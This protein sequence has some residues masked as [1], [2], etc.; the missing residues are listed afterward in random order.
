M[1]K[2]SFQLLACALLTALA[3]LL[4]PASA[5]AATNQLS[6]LQDDREFLGGTGENLDA[7]AAELKN[8]GVDI[9]RTNVN[10]NK[11]YR[12]PKDRKKPSDFV[13]SDPNN[14]H[15][16]WSAMDRLVALAKANDVKI[17]MTIT[18]PGPFFASE[19]PSKCRKLPCTYKPK[20]TEFGQFAAA[21]AKRYK[22]KADYYA[23]WNEPNIGKTWLTPRF[24]KRRGVGT[25]DYAAAKY[26]QLYFAGYKSIAKYDRARRNRVLFGETAAISKPVAVPARR[27]VPGLQGQ[28][29]PRP[30]RPRP[31][32]LGR[33]KKVN[34]LGFAHHPY[35]QGGNG[36]PRS[37]SR[38]KSSI[39]IAYTPRLIRLIDGA[40]RRGRIARG[41]GVYITE[42]GYQSNPP[43]R[44]SNVSPTEQGQYLNESDRLFYG[45]SR[46]KWVAQYELTDVPQQDQFNS[47]LRFVGGKVKPAYA[48]Y[49]MPIVVTRRSANSVEV[50]GQSRPGGSAT[51]A[52]QSQAAGGQFATVRT[53]RTN[54]Q[55]MFRV[56]ISKKSAFRLKWRLSGISNATGATITSREAKAGRKLAFYR[57]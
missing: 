33:V 52:I 41:R 12:T 57:N 49:R 14:S 23:I 38:T 20:T 28:P 37:K 18:G 10:Y 25:I 21:V 3:A 32:L 54:A 26:R 43:D 17:L 45:S 16:D 36:T 31:G 40:A 51:V 5:S 34:T 7:A 4:A 19:N 22:G 8:L 11:I 15:Y 53:I 35:N 56:N 44:I 46:V 39:P 1:T 13:T 6:L 30:P 2:Q 50:Y 55:G 27:A 24:E 42:F 48:A 29:V 47:G 9:L